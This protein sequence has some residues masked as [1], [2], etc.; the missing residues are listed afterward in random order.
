[1]APSSGGKVTLLLRQLKSGDRTKFEQL[2]ELVYP[3]LRRLAGHHFR[4][5]RPGHV[6]QPTALVNEAYLRLVA[7]EDQTWESR[8]HFFGAAAQLMRR[9]LIEH[10]RTVQAKKRGGRD[11]TI[12]LDGVDVP[13]TERPIDLLAL[14][15]ALT[16][17]E[18]VSP[19]QARIVELRYFAGMSVP[20][21]AE[22][23]G[24]DPR[25]VDRDW[26]VA[27]AWLRLRLQP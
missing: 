3:D 7:H 15:E 26:A 16:N 11:G 20:E 5:E 22:A 9:I 14:D 23:I 4:A 25:T 17:L 21:V 8:A 18:K 13:S 12:P 2:L 10:A 6:L 19:R 27:R 24:M 1:M